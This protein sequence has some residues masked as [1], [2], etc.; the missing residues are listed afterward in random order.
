MLLMCTCIAGAVWSLICDLA[1]PHSSTLLSMHAQG[2]TVEG[3]LASVVRG[4]FSF[5]SPAWSEVTP[6][7]QDLV[8]GLLTLEVRPGMAITWRDT[9]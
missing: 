8:R 5:E 2:T 4:V 1:H 6:H 9:C 3:I 7:A